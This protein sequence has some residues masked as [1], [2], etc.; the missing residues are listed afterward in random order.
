VTI[1][2]PRVVKRID[3]METHAPKIA[4]HW[5]TSATD[6]S[7]DKRK[8]DDDSQAEEAEL[9]QLVDRVNAARSVY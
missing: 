3:I 4:P 7:I 1:A 9:E 6:S 2:Q 5:S 8:H